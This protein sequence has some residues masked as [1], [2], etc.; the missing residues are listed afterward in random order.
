M[1]GYTDLALLFKERENVP[2]YSP[3]FGIIVSLPDIKIQC[4]SKVVLDEA[5][6][7]AIFDIKETVQHDTY[8]EYIHLNKTVVLLPYNNSQ[9]FIAIGVLNE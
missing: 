5:N 3:I 1:S 7:K 9:K 2:F 4:G 6:I 8:T